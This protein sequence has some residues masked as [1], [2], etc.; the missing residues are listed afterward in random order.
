MWSRVSP[1]LFSSLL[2]LASLTLRP[3]PTA[4]P[5]LPLTNWV[6]CTRAAP[7]VILHLP[8]VSRPSSKRGP[9]PA[10]QDPQPRRPT[11]ASHQKASTARHPPT[12]SPLQTHRPA[13]ATLHP[14][15]PCRLLPP[16]AVPSE[17]RQGRGRPG[18]PRRP[19]RHQADSPVAALPSGSTRPHFPHYRMVRFSN[20]DCTKLNNWNVAA[21]DFA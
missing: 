10:V 21:L 7:L 3:R 18:P 15:H 16:P 4:G 1:R 20:T 12:P 9:S 5:P 8:L 17:A 19:A 6:S 13:L 14:R 11:H 2:R